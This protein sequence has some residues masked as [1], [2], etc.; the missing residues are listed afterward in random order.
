M[1]IVAINQFTL[2][3]FDRVAQIFCQSATALDLLVN[4]FGAMRC[5]AETSPDLNYT[6][7]VTGEP[8]AF[9]ITRPGRPPFLA[10][11]TGELI[12][13]LEKD[14]TIQLQH[15][16]R[17]L[18]FIHGAALEFDGNAMLLVAPSGQGKSTTTWGLLH[19]GF[20][21]LSDELAPTDLETMH[22]HPYPH[23]L[24]LK[25]Q[26]PSA[27]P[28][29]SKVART[30]RTLHVPE[31]VLPSAT[32]S[33]PLHIRTLILLKYCP[34]E[35]SAPSLVPISKGEAAARLYTQALNPLAH[36]DD[37]LRGAVAI[38]RAADCYAL[39][40]ADLRSTC[41]LLTRTFLRS[42]LVERGY[43]PKVS[44]YDA[45][46]THLELQSIARRPAARK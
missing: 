31:S 16:R 19:H 11:D 8:A 37:G 25:K 2:R 7:E 39:Y 10:G 27:Y 1:N 9:R 36:K 42:T 44:G 38:S 35:E 3:S 12:Y 33:Q 43:Y 32:V 40:S 41:E 21:Y 46:S 28:L 29:P 24:C 34:N 4:V 30:R 18:Y 23:A 22:V 14:L 13:L 6:V 15:L 20:G 26:P 17:D 5:N 45:L